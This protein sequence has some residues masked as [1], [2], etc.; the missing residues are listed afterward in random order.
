PRR[1]STVVTICALDWSPLEA[2]LREPRLRVVEH[3]KWTG[4]PHRQVYADLLALLRDRWRCE[5][6]VVDATGVGA[7]VASFLRAALGE[8]LVEPFVFGAPSKSALAYHLLEAIDAGRLS[9]YRDDGSPEWR[10]CRQQ[11]RL[12]RYRVAAQ[13]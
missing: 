5:R 6:V 4:R 7:G 13:Q 12:A 8:R 3:V 2:R 10:R 1:D 9:L 11:L